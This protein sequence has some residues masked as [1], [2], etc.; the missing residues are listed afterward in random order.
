MAKGRGQK[1]KQAVNEEI[2]L[3]FTV[4]DVLKVARDFLRKYGASGMTGARLISECRKAFKKFG[5]N[6][7]PIGAA[8][9]K[10]A[11]PSTYRP[12]GPTCPD[13]CPFLG[14]SCYAEAG[15]TNLSQKRS[16]AELVASVA[17][18]ACAMISAVLNNDTARLQVSG[19]LLTP[20]D[21]GVKK[22][23]EE[24]IDGL[25]KISKML[26]RSS[27]RVPNN[28][29]TAYLYTH[30]RPAFYD[31]APLREA[32]IEV[33]YSDQI[34]A[35]GAISVP[36]RSLDEVKRKARARGLN[37]VV[38]PAQNKRGIPVSCRGCR[39]CFDATEKER[40]IIFKPE[41]DSVL[42]EPILPGEGETQVL[43]KSLVPESMTTEQ[44]QAMRANDARKLLRMIF[45]YDVK[46]GRRKVVPDVSSKKMKLHR[47]YLA[48]AAHY[49]VTPPAKAKPKA[50]RQGRGQRAKR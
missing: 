33:I 27:R 5:V 6:M 10:V 46:E 38:C 30:L 2:N 44:L 26:R 23:D 25:I 42:G 15:R 7:N 9:E 19:D 31:R 45:K 49:R 36:E 32:G 4:D 47:V 21:E 3:D 37:P 18:A 40:V 34:M 50:P 48:L 17:A 29:T 39:L 16:Q 11:L 20:D 24:Y 35:G 41:G 14:I 12:V 28:A 1:K 8:N 22:L 13:D 43:Y